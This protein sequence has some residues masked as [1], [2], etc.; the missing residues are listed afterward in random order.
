M[1]EHS[2]P[3][4]AIGGIG[5]EG[6]SLKG[7]R[8]VLGRDMHRMF[9]SQYQTGILDRFANIRIKLRETIRTLPGKMVIQCIIDKIY[10]MSHIHHSS[11]LY[12]SL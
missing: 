2:V 6:G 1:R 3:T 4:T 8:D 10:G 12:S 9:T 5:E 7:G 11:A